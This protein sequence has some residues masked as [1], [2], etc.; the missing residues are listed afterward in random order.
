MEYSFVL[1]ERD[2]EEHNMRLEV[3]AIV[4]AVQL[5]RNISGNSLQTSA[6]YWF[7]ATNV[8]LILHMGAGN[9]W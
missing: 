8:A 3:N 7:S 1:S 2:G 5:A 9:N 4:S 6:A